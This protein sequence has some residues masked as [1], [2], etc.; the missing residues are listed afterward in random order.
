[1]LTGIPAVL[2][3]HGAP[4]HA[5]NRLPPS[6]VVQVLDLPSTGSELTSAWKTVSAGIR[7]HP[8]NVDRL[9]CGVPPK[10]TV[11]GTVTAPPWPS[12]TETVK[13]SVAAPTPALG[14]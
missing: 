10:L 12:T 6:S 4:P 8:Q 14:V 7:V 9:C 11:T 1:M 3:S 2:P 5:A 13:A